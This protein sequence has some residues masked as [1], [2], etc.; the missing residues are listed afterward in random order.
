MYVNVCNIIRT[1]TTNKIK[2]EFLRICP[3]QFQYEEN[4]QD[5]DKLNKHNY[6]TG[7]NATELNLNGL[8]CTEM[9]LIIDFKVTKKVPF[10][11]TL[12]TSNVPNTWADIDALVWRRDFIVVSL[13]HWLPPLRAKSTCNPTRR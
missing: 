2:S 5:D 3:I 8:K 9:F 1:A 7:D 6:C 4:D 11:S 13:P 10:F 12:H